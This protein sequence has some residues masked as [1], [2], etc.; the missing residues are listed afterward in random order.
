MKKNHMIIILLFILFAPIIFL[1]FLLCINIYIDNQKTK[2]EIKSIE[3][4]VIDYIHETYNCPYENIE[5]ISVE[6]GYTGWIDPYVVPDQA[7][8][9]CEGEIINVYRDSVYGWLKRDTNTS[10]IREQNERAQ[11]EEKRDK[12]TEEVEKELKNIKMKYN[13]DCIYSLITY[14]YTNDVIVVINGSD[15]SIREKVDVLNKVY[16]SVSSDKNTIAEKVDARINYTVLMVNDEQTF[17][18]FNGVNFGLNTYYWDNSLT[19]LIEQFGYSPE[20]LNEDK[21]NYSY[22]DVVDALTKCNKE[23]NLLIVSLNDNNYY[24]FKI[25][26]NYE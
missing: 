16:N 8:V 4:E 26:Y 2:A 23:D 19:S 25:K 24:I 22:N 21:N 7:K 17:N 12:I 13:I 3:K 11:Q 18:R 10:E 6:K 9:S 1:V 14:Y 5:V 20:R 15:Y